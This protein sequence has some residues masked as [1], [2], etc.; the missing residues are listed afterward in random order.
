MRRTIHILGARR[1]FLHS[2]CFWVGCG[3]LNIAKIRD[4]GGVP[5]AVGSS[6]LDLYDRLRLIS[7]V[8]DPRSTSVH[9]DGMKFSCRD[10]NDD[11][12]IRA[13]YARGIAD[14]ELC[15][16]IDKP[17][18]EGGALYLGSLTV[19]V[20]LS[21]PSLNKSSNSLAVLLDASGRADGGGSGT[22]SSL[23]YCRKFVSE[24]NQVL[25]NAMRSKRTQ[26]SGTAYI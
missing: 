16:F 12:R 21:W 26:D 11:C 1:G 17:S 18:C 6:S 19:S 2:F 23:R 24:A 4:L 8:F 22:V 5:L 7:L 13:I 25:C 14:S 10:P 3:E 20:P 15:I 9:S